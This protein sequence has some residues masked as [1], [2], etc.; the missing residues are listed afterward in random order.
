VAKHYLTDAKVT[1]LVRPVKPGEAK[2]QSQPVGPDPSAAP[3][4]KG[5]L[6]TRPPRPGPDWTKLPGPAEPASFRPPPYTRRKLSNG[7]DLW[8]ATWKTLPLVQISLQSQVGTGDDPEGK[9]GLANLT[10]RL[11]D[12]GTATK[13]ATELAEAFEELG[14]GVRAAAGA[15]DIGVGASVL[16]RNLEPTL[17]L[18]AEMLISPRFDPKDF[19]RER[20][21]QLAD[22]LQG[23]DNV[24]WIARRVFPILMFGPNHPY[25]KPAQGYPET[26]K[27]LTLDD[28]RAFHK[29]ALGPRHATLIVTGDVDPDAVTSVLEKTLGRWRND[30]SDPRPRPDSNQKAEPG[31]IFLVDKPGAVQSVIYVGRRW[32]DRRDPSYMATLI[33]NHL[34]GEDFL[35]RLNQNLREQHGYSYGAGSGFTFH[36]SKSFWRVATSVRTDATAPALKEI[37]KELDALPRSKPITA[38]EISQ[39][40]SSEAR[41]FPESFESPSGISGELAEI[42]EFGLPADYLETFLMN[43]EKTSPADIQHSMTD[44]VSPAERFILVVGDRKAVEPELKKAGM[45]RVKPVTIDGKPV[46]K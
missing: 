21:Q 45:D 11:L 9:S 23:P 39:A 8:I 14:A 41:T 24:S 32:V 26:V 19:D 20:S 31:T 27:A 29:A 35:S 2:T 40:K 12:Q 18:V 3:D 38:E 36:R 33:G 43:L 46:K 22:L 30:N 4:V 13:T 28:V 16:K 6:A 10:A 34:L 25:G 1:L 44:V 17:E 37:I 7:I 5:T 15:D 42:A